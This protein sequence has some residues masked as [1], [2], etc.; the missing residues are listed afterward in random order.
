MHV[1][2]VSQYY[3]HPEMIAASLRLR[4]LAAGLADRGHR[5]D[6]IC[7]VPNHPQGIVHPGYARR[8][9][10]QRELDGMRVTYVWACSTT[11][12]AARWRLATYVTYAVSATLVGAA[13]KRPDVVLD[14]PQTST[15]RT[16]SLCR[17]TDR[18]GLIT[19]PSRF[20]PLA[21]CGQPVGRLASGGPRHG[22]GAICGPWA[23]P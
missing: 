6:V 8:A 18:G 10:V 13:R 14:E 7:E 9:I 23:I 4:P 17:R 3:L 16:G 5:V 11:S 15:G 1:L 22:S 20:G 19:T 12:K 21:L 2:L